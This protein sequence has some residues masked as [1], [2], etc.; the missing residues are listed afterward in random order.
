MSGM[1]AHAPRSVG[2]AAGLWL[3]AV[4]MGALETALAV[5]GM[6]VNGTATPGDLAFGL[7]LRLV[8]FAAAVAMVANL[9]QGRNWARLGLTVLLGVFGTLSLVIGP[10]QFL[11]DGGD[12]GRALAEADM[13]SW[14]FG[15]SRVVHLA[16]VLGAM[17]LMYQKASNDYFA[18]NVGA[19]RLRTPGD[20]SAAAVET[21]T[22]AAQTTIADLASTRTASRPASKSPSGPNINDP[23]AS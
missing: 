23:S 8:V 10:V 17:I 15:L 1:N 21:R 6:L 12:V 14:A 16:A 4:G 9:R 18:G 7:G 20:S 2:A 13:A 11:L 19:R 22:T 3:L 5:G